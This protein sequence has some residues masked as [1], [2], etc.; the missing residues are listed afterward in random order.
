MSRYPLFSGALWQRCI[1]SEHGGYVRLILQYWVRQGSLPDDDVQLARIVGVSV[2]KWRKMR[3]TIEAL[4]EPGWKHTGLDEQLEYAATRREK[5]RNAAN[6]RHGTR[7][8]L[9]VVS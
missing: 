5:A 1:V 7:P 3:P 6:S 8:A 2:A 9:R 4:F